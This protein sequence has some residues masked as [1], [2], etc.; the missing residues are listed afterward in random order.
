MGQEYQCISKNGNA[1]MEQSFAAEEGHR[2]PLPPPPTPPPLELLM[3]MH[4]PSS[5][6]ATPS[7][8]PHS[9]QK[10]KKNRRLSEKVRKKIK[11]FNQFLNDTGAM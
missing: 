3:P 1:F 6:N 7:I 10:L 2:A 9:E 5:L 8:V 11:I 4:S